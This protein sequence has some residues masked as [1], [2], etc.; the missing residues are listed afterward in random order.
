MCQPTEIIDEP[1]DLAVGRI[2]LSLQKLL[3]TRGFADERRLCK[4]SVCSTSSL[5][6]SGG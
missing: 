2:N 3:V 6:I 4:Y 5:M 1:V